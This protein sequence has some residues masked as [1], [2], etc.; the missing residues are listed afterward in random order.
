MSLCLFP[1][2]AAAA[3]TLLLAHAA[4]A[5]IPQSERDALI[6]LYNSAGGSSWTNNTGWNGAPGTEC[7]WFG[8]T[9][10]S[11]SSTVTAINLYTNKL[12]GTLSPISAFS[13]L[14]DFNV[15]GN[16]MS[17]PLPSL[18]G[19]KALQSFNAGGTYTGD[20]NNFSGPIPSLSGLT[21]LKTIGLRYNQ[22]SGQIPSLSGLTSLQT[23]ELGNNQLSGQMPSLQGLAALR[24]F[25]VTTNQLTGPLPSLD[26]LSNLVYMNFFGNQFSGSIP[27]L[28]GVP[29]LQVFDASYNQ[30]TGT[31]PPLSGFSALTDFYVDVNNLTGTI[32]ALDGLTQLQFF[33]VGGN[34]LT[35]QLPSL[36]GLTSLASFRAYYNQLNGPIPALSGLS[37]LYDFEVGGNQLSGQMPALA[38][39]TSLE[40]FSAGSNQLTG[41]IPSLA[42]L[43]ALVEFQVDTNQLSGPIPALSGSTALTKFYA[44][45]NQLT[46]PIPSLSGLTALATFQVPNNQLNGPIPPLSG[47]TALKDF[48]VYSNNLTG[49]I[50][51]LSGLTALETFS[52]HR[53]QL[54]GSLPSLSGLPKLVFFYAYEN[55]LTGSLPSLSGLTALQ[56]FR[57]YSNQLSGSI[58]SLTGL[59][60]LVIFD[61]SDNRLT[62]SLPSLSGL[63]ALY[64]F[65]V[66]NNLLSG[67][68]PQV[69]QPNHLAAYNSSLCPNAI[70]TTPDPAWDAATGS[71]PWY[72]QCTHVESSNGTPTSKDSTQIVLSRDGKIKIFQSLQTD[73]TANTA[74]AGGQDVY[75]VSAD[76]KPVLESVDSAGNKL[77]GMAGLPAVSP[78]GNIIAFL[79]TPAAAKSA[80][81][82]VTGQMFAG[83]R[84]QP[85][86]RVDTGMGGI[87]P[88][89][90]ANGAPSLSSVN[91]SNQL[92]FCSSAS[93]LVP[94]DGN[95]ARDIFLVDPLN[96]SIIAQRISLDSA[97]SELPGDSCEPKLSSDGNNVVFSLSAPTL[98]STSARQIV[99]KQ[100][101]AGK[102]LLS[103]QLLPITTNS[104]GQGASADSSEPVINQDGSVIAFTSQANLDGIGTPIGGREV[105][106]SLAQPSGRLV[107]RARSGDGT[108]PDGASQHPQLSDDGTAVAMQTAATN[109]LRPLL[110]A[111]DV[112]A[113]AP[114]QCGAVAITTNFFSVAALGGPL[115]S[116]NSTT[117][118]SPSISGDGT[119]SGFDSNAPQANGNTNRNAYAQ[120]IGTYTGVTGT[121]LP[122]LSGDY[123]GQWFD[124]A[125][126]G[127][128]LVIDV[129]K[130]DANNDRLV[131]LTW[132]VFANG[133]PTWMQ[134]VGTAHAGTGSAADTVVV[135]MD[136]VAIFQGA[137]FPLGEAHAAASVWGS[138]TLT[139]SDAN[140]G[141]MSWRSTYPGFSS[142]SMPLKH[143]LAVGLP[144]QDA[145]G[146]Q[147][148]S[149]YSGNWF[150]PAQSGHGFEFEVLPTTTAAFLAVDWFAFAPNGAPVWL[151]GAGP[152][153]GNSAQMHLQ[154]IDGA[155]AQ[156]PPNYNPNAITQHDWG[157]ATFTFADSSHGSVTWNSTIAG[158][159]SGTQ[160][161]QPLATG[162]MDRRGCQ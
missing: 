61:V 89:G 112:T 54:S 115:C 58:P 60:S 26:G 30:L 162:L 148:T 28:A 142:G 6:A 40:I 97:G 118:Q 16:K 37:N 103:G 51:S 9:C 85:K 47:L 25:S 23:F 64:G 131:L 70:T 117:N 72:D 94:S 96:S 143:F 155:G 88:N 33:Q 49:P 146:A 34:H 150:N 160:P 108:V 31:I 139:F 158:Y 113:V 18:S 4:Q 67:P 157:T 119:A 71:S 42:G 110:L 130:P 149:C 73:L 129:V 90:S 19:L 27:S 53:N 75:S 138:I 144:A 59:T 57:A 79:F 13:N 52:V 145:P 156:F 126:N 44:N 161:L 124:P 100:L 147:V 151:S 127:Q 32:P 159:G 78:D 48:V 83:A 137:S 136:Q 128:G 56:E 101:S 50:P 35:G 21:A 120:G 62:G 93:N 29:Q 17:G 121:K 111:K 84:G 22:L 135:Q 102:V 140:T 55:Q 95:S 134:G 153:N 99:L 152:I 106:I 122:N 114:P 69:P 86:H 132:F 14:Q 41:S 20:G 11:T 123:S 68:L 116:S 5:Q 81:D 92:V 36:A 80:K 1:R 7:T 87:P 125:Q 141:R 91:G 82:V 104:N 10:D 107:K 46:G 38:G 8:I 133:Q 77:I 43:T 24:G 12:T 154:L 98:F 66:G 15:D 39:L 105:F 63:S 65:R 109:F 3:L 76:G 2:A 74:N 45:S